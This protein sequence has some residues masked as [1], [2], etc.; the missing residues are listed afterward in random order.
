MEKLLSYSRSHFFKDNIR[1][2]FFLRG[3]L[4]TGVS[5]EIKNYGVENLAFAADCEAVQLAKKQFL[6]IEP[7][8]DNILHYYLFYLGDKSLEDDA[9][10]L[11]F[12]LVGVD[13]YITECL[14]PFSRAMGKNLREYAFI[15]FQLFIFLCKEKREFFFVDAE[16]KDVTNFKLDGCIELST[17][18]V[19]CLEQA[20]F[21][22]NY[23]NVM[24]IPTVLN[25]NGFYLKHGKELI[26]VTYA[27][28]KFDAA[29]IAASRNFDLVKSAF[30]T[31]F[32]T[33]RVVIL[34]FRDCVENVRPININCAVMIFGDIG[35]IFCDLKNFFDLIDGGDSAVVAKHYEVP[36]LFAWCRFCATPVFRKGL[37][38]YCLHHGQV[39]NKSIVYC[40]ANERIRK[41]PQLK[42]FLKICPYLEK[43]V[44][45][46]CVFAKSEYEIKVWKYLR[47]NGT[48]AFEKLVRYDSLEIAPTNKFDIYQ[49]I[50][51]LVKDKNMREL[52][53]VLAKIGKD[54]FD[55]LNINNSLSSM[56]IKDIE[57]L[58][59]FL[60][61]AFEIYPESS[62]SELFGGD[63]VYKVITSKD[64]AF[65]EEFLNKT[66]NAELVVDEPTL[67]FLVANDKF[68]QFK[69]L[70][71]NHRLDDNL[72]PIVFVCKLKRP[73][74]ELLHNRILEF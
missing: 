5:K 8:S 9:L 23:L 64:D 71:T 37:V 60:K 73:W 19:D 59:C 51:C 21:F 36:E 49:H 68:D 70:I 45:D 46:T 42:Y 65:I 74:A 24:V 67:D 38:R 43:C 35:N 32:E 44:D 30:Q 54:N 33:F 40:N 69:K 25:D 34:T 53:N 13:S 58:N 66:E 62:R 72:E 1:F 29:A 18:K 52:E 57:V 20:A 55:A 28:N 31:K 50:E 17:E 39:C 47:Y 3:I 4:K 7:A 6:A 63:L 56:F 15:Y 2:N 27:V 26:F 11:N 61:F 22:E 14:D 12:R 41:L 48:A 10:L 16:S